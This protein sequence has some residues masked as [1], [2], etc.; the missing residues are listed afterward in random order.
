MGLPLGPTFANIF[1]CYH[2]KLWLR[3]CPDHFKPVF[4]TRY[5]DDTFVLLFRDKSHYKLFLNYINSK[6]VNINFTVETE[7]TNSLSFLDVNVSRFNNKFITSVYRKPTF[8]GQGISFFSFTLFL[9]KLNTIKTLVFRS[10][11]ICSNYHDR[12]KEFNFLKDFFVSNG[13]PAN[14]I[15]SVIKHFLD[16]RINTTTTTTTVPDEATENIKYISLPFLV[17]NQRN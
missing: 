2:E 5:V 11:S 13:F 9:F 10:Y 7:S 12:H 8:S 1:M 6:H 14:L 15:L 16:R 3:E 4:Y 17:L